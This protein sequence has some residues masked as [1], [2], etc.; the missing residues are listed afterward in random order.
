MPQLRL[1]FGY[2]G[3]HIYRQERRIYC[4]VAAGPPDIHQ[5][6]GQFQDSTAHDS[7]AQGPST[8]TASGPS[9]NIRTDEPDAAPSVLPASLLCAG[10]LLSGLV[11]GVVLSSGTSSSTAAIAPASESVALTPLKTRDIGDALVSLDQNAAHKA[12]EDAK[13]CKAPLVTLIVRKE[14]GSAGVIIRVQSGSYLSPPIQLTDASQRLA[15]PFPAPYAA[16]KGVMSVVGSAQGVLVFMDPGWK[17][18]SL[19]GNATRPVYWDTEK[20]CPD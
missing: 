3:R 18:D 10:A 17:I 12:I 11:A 7:P 14:S 15:V 13:S 8:Q 4:D 16:G 2:G 20:P 6:Q 9:A 1:A 5:M 19:Q